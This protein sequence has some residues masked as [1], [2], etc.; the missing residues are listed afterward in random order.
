M[1]QQS[2]VFLGRRYPLRHLAD[3]QVINQFKAP[4]LSIKW[5]KLHSH[6]G[7]PSSLDGLLHDPKNKMDTSYQKSIIVGASINRWQPKLAGWFS[8]TSHQHGLFAG[9]PMTWETFELI[10]EIILNHLKYVAV[11]SWFIKEKPRKACLNAQFPIE[12]PRLPISASSTEEELCQSTSTGVNCNCW[13]NS[14]AGLRQGKPPQLGRFHYFPT[15]TNPQDPCM[16]Y[17]LT[18]GVY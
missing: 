11:L 6:G 17:M 4:D 5:G 18:F 16:A 8:G 3:D 15:I 9:S 10:P 13:V 12:L 14:P 7:S 2:L 1:D